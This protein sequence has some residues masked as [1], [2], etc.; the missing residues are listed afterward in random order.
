MLER[1]IKRSHPINAPIFVDPKSGIRISS[2]RW[3]WKIKISMHLLTTLNSRLWKWETSNLPLWLMLRGGTKQSKGCY[4]LGRVLVLHL[5]TH[6][7]TAPFLGYNGH[8]NPMSRWPGVNIEAKTPLNG[9][10]RAY[11]KNW[12]NLGL[13]MV[14]CSKNIF[15]SK[16]NNAL[17]HPRI[18]K[19][20]C[21]HQ[22]GLRNDTSCKLFSPDLRN[23][24]H[25]RKGLPL[26]GMQ[27]YW[28]VEVNI[29]IAHLR[30][31]TGR[32][33]HQAGL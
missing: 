25:K 17:Q 9:Q 1:S 20:Y 21:Q 18:A 4:L 19:V 24:N 23:W 31:T 16:S 14:K 15:L 10:N 5:I 8:A 33:E 7:L 30:N 22:A 12:W 28:Y 29:R 11:T 2:K 3:E 13:L 26:P 27:E 32:G 6:D